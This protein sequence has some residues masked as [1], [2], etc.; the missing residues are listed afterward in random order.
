MQQNDNPAG[1]VSNPRRAY[2]SGAQRLSVAPMMDGF[3]FSGMPWQVN[4][5][6]ENQKPA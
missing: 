6:A 2:I 4:C 1:P 5:L 3:T